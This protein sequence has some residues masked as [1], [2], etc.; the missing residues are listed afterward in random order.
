MTVWLGREQAECF[1]KDD[2]CMPEK[3]P[4]RMEMCVLLQLPGS[5]L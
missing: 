4:V 3:D 5:K 2:H 1:W